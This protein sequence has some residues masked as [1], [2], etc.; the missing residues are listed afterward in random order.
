MILYVSV[1]DFR[2]VIAYTYDVC[3]NTN[4][5]DI[6]QSLCLPLYSKHTFRIPSGF[7]CKA[8]SFSVVTTGIFGRKLCQ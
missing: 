1:Q 8:T 5:R 3:E 4:L 2:V 7:C 6:C